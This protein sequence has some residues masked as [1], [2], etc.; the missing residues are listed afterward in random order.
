MIESEVSR[1]GQPV[2]KLNGRYLASS[3]DPVKEAFGWANRA[4]VDLG[5]KG[6]AIILG[7]GCGYHVAALKERCP[8]IHV[9]AL[10]P[11][12][13]VAHRALEWNP[14]L[15]AHNLLV[16]DDLSQMTEAP[17]LRDAMAGTFAL[18]PHLPTTEAYADWALTTSRFLLGRDRLSF[19]LQLRMRPDLHALMDPKKIAAL[20]E[21]PVSIKTIQRLFSDSSAF[22]RERQ[23]W[24][25][26]EELV[27]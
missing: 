4:A 8:N 3:F 5:S 16:V 22:S 19:L 9:L 13:Q 21:A 20:G 11:N 10:E 18:L 26:L 1:S 25:V 14:I 24:K 12:E 23:I 6:A 7:A 15:Q 27:L 2:L 17:Q